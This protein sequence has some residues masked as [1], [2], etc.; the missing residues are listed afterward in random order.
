MTETLVVSVVVAGVGGVLTAV[1]VT[2]FEVV[3]RLDSVSLSS[4][5]LDDDC[6]RF[7]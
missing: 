2:S 7:R 6:D 1:S 4:P 3:S 5:P